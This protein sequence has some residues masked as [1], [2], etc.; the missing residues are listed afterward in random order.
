M[1]RTKTAIELVMLF[2]VAAFAIGQAPP[3][4]HQTATQS[5]CSN[6]VALSGAKVDCSNLTPEQ[7]K[8]LADIPAIMKMALENKN[9][10]DAILAKLNEFKEQ[11]STVISAPNCPNGICPTAP[12][13]GNQTVNNGPPPPKLTWKQEN[14]LCPASAFGKVDIRMMLDRVPATLGFIATCDHPCH[15]GGAVVVRPGERDFREFINEESVNP[16]TAVVLMTPESPIGAGQEI[17]WGLTSDD[18]ALFTVTDVKVIPE[19]EA[20]KLS[21][22]PR[23]LEVKGNVFCHL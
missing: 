3:T 12:N 17:D 11:P 14:S 4:V 5:S 21:R 18:N 23:S 1:I 16:N 2:S 10:L 20:S 15:S 8:S 22:V 7:R 9:Y 13:F 6:I 19:E